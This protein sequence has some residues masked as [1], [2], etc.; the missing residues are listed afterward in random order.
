[1]GITAGA[2]AP[3]HLVREVVD[4]FKSSGVEAV[5][6]IDAVEERVTFV[7]PPELSRE[8]VKRGTSG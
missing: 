8:L 7:P 4:Y 3:E 5:E 2:S 6:E 1:V